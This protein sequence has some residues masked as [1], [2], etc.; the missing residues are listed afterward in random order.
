VNPQRDYFTRDGAETLT[1]K[2]HE[3]WKD[4]GCEVYP[5][6]VEMNLHE[7]VAD[8]K[9]HVVRSDMVG[10]RPANLSLPQNRCARCAWWEKQGLAVRCPACDAPADGVG[11]N[12]KASDD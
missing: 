3:Y 12:R 10:G 5:E 9:I 8:A 4:R 1:A 6:I 7:S 2:I 11:S